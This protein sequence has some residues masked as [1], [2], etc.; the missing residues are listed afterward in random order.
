M[1]D[2]DIYKQFGRVIGECEWNAT[3]RLIHANWYE[4]PYL[5]FIIWIEHCKRWLKADFRLAGDNPFMGC[6]YYL[7]LFLLILFVISFFIIIV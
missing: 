4:K 6:M 1:S 7:S 2:Y 3:L 5:K